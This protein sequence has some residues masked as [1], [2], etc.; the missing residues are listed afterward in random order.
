VRL[1]IADEAQLRSAFAQIVDRMASAVPGQPATGV[2][3]AEMVPPG[4]EFTM[5][6]RRDPVFGPMLMFGLGG[7]F[8]EALKDVRLAPAPLDHAEARALVLGIRAS[9]LLQGARGRRAAD[10]DRIAGLLCRLGDF[11][12]ANADLVSDIDLNPLVLLDRADDEL[13]LLDALIVLR[14]RQEGEGP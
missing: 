3:V 9:A 4:I 14:H 7:I 13:R 1:G 6:A 12:V 11:A 5:G 10:I 2:L 8:V